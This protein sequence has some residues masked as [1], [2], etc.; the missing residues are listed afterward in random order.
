MAY[1][2]PSYYFISSEHHIEGNDR[3][4]C[5]IVSWSWVNVCFA[6]MRTVVPEEETRCTETDAEDDNHSA[7]SSDGD[8]MLE[9]VSKLTEAGVRGFVGRLGWQHDSSDILHRLGSLKRCDRP[10]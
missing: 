2:P 8:L 5:L 1:F 3:A 10:S 7:S 9:F 4:L 6:G